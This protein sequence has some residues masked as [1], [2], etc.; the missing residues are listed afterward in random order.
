[1]PSICQYYFVMPWDMAKRL[2]GEENKEVGLIEQET[3][4][5][6]L[7]SEDLETIAR[8]LKD[9]AEDAYSLSNEDYG[10]GTA[11]KN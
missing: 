1:M 11:V 6:S 7:A 5:Y 9:E 3:G 4:E 2:L 8:R 10:E